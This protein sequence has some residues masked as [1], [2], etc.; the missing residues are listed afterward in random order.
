MARKQKSHTEAFLPFGLVGLLAF[1]PQF[2]KKGNSLNEYQDCK[3]QK[4]YIT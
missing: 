3:E 1:S 4:C 2:V